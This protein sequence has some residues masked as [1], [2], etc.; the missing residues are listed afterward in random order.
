MIFAFTSVEMKEYEGTPCTHHQL[1]IQS[2]QGQTATLVYWNG[3]ATSGRQLLPTTSHQP[4]VLSELS[5]DL[6]DAG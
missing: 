5:E 2:I 6:R 4:L 1:Q 3:L